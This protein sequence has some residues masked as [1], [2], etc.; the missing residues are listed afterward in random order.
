MRA[1]RARTAATEPERRWRRAIRRDGHLDLVVGSPSALG[2]RGGVDVLK[3]DAESLMGAYSA[4]D[5]QVSL[6]GPVPAPASAAPSRS[7][8]STATPSRSSPSAYRRGPGLRRRRRG[9]VYAG[10]RR[11]RAIARARGPSR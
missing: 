2:N 3:G 10:G 6:V 8:T 9:Y 1:L 5:A 11:F 7:V 4:A